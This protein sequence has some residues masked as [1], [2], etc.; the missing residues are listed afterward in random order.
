MMLPAAE[1]VAIA[2]IAVRA[3]STW[4][5]DVCSWNALRAIADLVAI[6]RIGVVAVHRP[7]TRWIGLVI[8]ADGPETS[9]LGTAIVVIDDVQSWSQFAGRPK[10]E[11]GVVQAMV[12][13]DT[14][15]LANAVCLSISHV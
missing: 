9:I 13:I 15:D 1:L 3:G 6:A 7:G 14:R 4:K 5:K 11:P 10:N 12:D 8:G 2:G